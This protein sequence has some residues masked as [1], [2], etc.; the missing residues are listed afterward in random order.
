MLWFWGAAEVRRQLCGV[1][2]FAPPLR[3]KELRP[4]GLSRYRLSP[5]PWELSF[6][7]FRDLFYVLGYFSCMHSYVHHMPGAA[8][9]LERSSS[10]L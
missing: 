5:R 9:P 4:P 3:G 10:Q 6:F 2:S 8:D 1:G 7:L